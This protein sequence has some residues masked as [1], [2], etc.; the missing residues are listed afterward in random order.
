MHV[1]DTNEQT[2]LKSL[3]FCHLWFL[4]FCFKQ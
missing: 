4:A 3:L 2:I 1:T